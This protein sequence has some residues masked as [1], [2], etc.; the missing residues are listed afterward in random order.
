MMPETEL[1]SA[2]ASDFND[3]L[4]LNAAEVKWTSPL[5][6]RRLAQLHA[7]STHHKLITV[8][9]RVAAFLLVMP[10]NTSYDSLNYLWFKQ[11]YA[12][13]MY[14]DRIVVNADFAGQ[15]LGSLLYQD[16]FSTAKNKGIKLITCEYNLQPMNK[17][18]ELFHQ[19]FGFQQ[20]DTQWLENN[21]KQV[22]LQV[23]DVEAYIQRKS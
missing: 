9:D 5:E 19:R 14:V 12:G 20:V 18:S 11:N 17:P 8:D 4:E 15:K 6:R 23:A 1:R 21:A 16:L 7:W 22:S 13:F 10:D 2:T 3:I